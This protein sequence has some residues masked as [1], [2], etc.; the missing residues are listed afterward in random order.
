M[1][2][3]LAAGLKRV[4]GS[5]SRANLTKAARMFARQAEKLG[6]RVSDIQRVAYLSDR[7]F[8]PL[9]ANYAQ[10][11]ENEVLTP[12]AQEIFALTRNY[13]GHRFDLLGSGWVQV[14]HGMRCAG[15][16]G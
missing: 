10:P 9:A 11:I 7:P 2:T 12:R 15:L 5:P 16:E 1:L 13:L 8:P 3:H 4:V 14:K 6:Q